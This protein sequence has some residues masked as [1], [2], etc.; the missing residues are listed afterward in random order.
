MLEAASGLLSRAGGVLAGFLGLGGRAIGGPVSAGGMYRVNERGPELLN[1][2]GRQ[3][4]M[5]GSQGGSV[6]P[7]AGGMVIHDNR[8]IHVGSN[9]SRAEVAQALE[10]SNRALQAQILQSRD[11]QG[12]FA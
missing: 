8:T 3:Y 5:M 1:V 7:N 12:A 4:L 6:S 10:A 9:V 2:A 11:R